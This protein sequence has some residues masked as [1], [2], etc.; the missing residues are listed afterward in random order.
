MHYSSKWL[1]TCKNHLSYSQRVLNSL[2]REESTLI[3]SGLFWN[4]PKKKSAG[5]H[6]E[7]SIYCQTFHTYTFTAERLGYVHFPWGPGTDQHHCSDSPVHSWRIQSSK[8]V[9]LHETH[10]VSQNHNRKSWITVTTHTRTHTCIDTLY[11]LLQL[12]SAPLLPSQIGW[13]LL[14]CLEQVHHLTAQ[15]RAH[16]HGAL[17]KPKY[18]C[19]Y[20]HTHT[21][22]LCVC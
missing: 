12:G 4:K 22:R 1:N 13:L 3:G 18:S 11:V 21:E 19:T 10:F 14:A 5:V 7:V 9:Q 17:T 20:T 16:M 15:L 8:D 2:W 6:E